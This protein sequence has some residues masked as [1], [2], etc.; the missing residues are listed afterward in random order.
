MNP[1][2][3]AFGLVL[4]VGML[5]LA[6]FYFWRQVQTLRSL[7]GD[8]FSPAEEGYL[9]ARARRRLLGSVV[10]A[11]LALFLAGSYF[12]EGEYQTF[13]QDREPAAEQE[14]QPPEQ[15]LLKPEEKNFLRRFTLYWII[16]LLLLFTFVIIAAFDTWATLRFGLEQH[17]QLQ[18][19]QKQA[20]EQQVRQIRRESNGRH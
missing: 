13:I 20:L 1:A 5:G 8:H 17:R 19:D 12:L 4:V 16:A 6:G 2:E 15:K 14:S 18:R 3:L 11:I 7:H 9:R 10:M